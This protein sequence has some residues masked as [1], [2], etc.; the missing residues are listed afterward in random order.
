VRVPGSAT[1]P[2]LID[3]RVIVLYHL[4]FV[5]SSVPPALALALVRALD[6]ARSFLLAL[7]LALALEFVCVLA[8][9][10]THARVRRTRH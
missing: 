2:S 6:L 7:A 4:A 10:L 9:A 3:R 5:P 8:L 1:G